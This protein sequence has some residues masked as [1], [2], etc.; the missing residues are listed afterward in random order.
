MTGADTSYQNPF[1]ERPHR[2]IGQRMRA[3]LLGANLEPKFWPYAFRMILRISN[4]E[5]HGKRDASPIEL[6]TGSKPNLRGRLRTFGCRVYVRELAHK[7]FEYSIEEHQ[8]RY[9]CFMNGRRDNPGALQVNKGRLCVCD[10][11]LC[12]VMRESV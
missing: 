6:M 11:G 2:T 8:N 10:P 5:P 7:V 3:M 1:G 9:G 12:A 4:I